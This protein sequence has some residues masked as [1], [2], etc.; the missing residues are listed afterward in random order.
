MILRRIGEG[1]SKA[2]QWDWQKAKTSMGRVFKP[3]ALEVIDREGAVIT[4]QPDMVRVI[5]KKEH[6]FGIEPGEALAGGLDRYVSR[7]FPAIYV[8]WLA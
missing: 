3:F 7:T 5:W 4:D 2:F 1:I 8:K 6:R